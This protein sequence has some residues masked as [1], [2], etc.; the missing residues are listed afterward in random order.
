[1]S[2]V[3][4]GTEGSEWTDACRRCVLPDHHLRGTHLGI[5]L[6]V[7]LSTAPAPVDPSTWSRDSYPVSRGVRSLPRTQEAWPGGRSALLLHR[8]P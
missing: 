2:S 6:P 8:A 5:L 3:A 1:M 7:L 4:L